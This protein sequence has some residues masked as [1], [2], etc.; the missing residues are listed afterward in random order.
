MI[1]SDK[2]YLFDVGVSNYLARRKPQ[3]GT[4]ELGRSLEHLVWM[5]LRAYKAYREPDLEMA[6]WRSASGF[7]VDFVLGNKQLALEVKSGR[8]HET[9]LKGLSALSDDGPVGQRLMVYL[10][11]AARVLHDRHGPVLCLPLGEFVERLWAG[12]LLV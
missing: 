2:F 1:K 7:E 4:P 12:A 3:P 11:K 10:E 6:Y 9:D 5:E 8:V